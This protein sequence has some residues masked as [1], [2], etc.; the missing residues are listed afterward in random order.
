MKNIEFYPMQAKHT[1]EVIRVREIKRLQALEKKMQ[2]MKTKI[3]IA[4]ILGLVFSLG[5]IIGFFI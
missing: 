3:Q 4:L 1:H 5:A 2:E